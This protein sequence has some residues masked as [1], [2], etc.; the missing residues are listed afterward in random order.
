[1]GSIGGPETSS[2]KKLQIYAASHLR[3]AKVSHRNHLMAALFENG[4]LFLFGWRGS[5]RFHGGAGGT[6]DINLFW[7]AGQCRRH[8]MPAFFFFEE[9]RYKLIDII[10]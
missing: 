6:D 5:G 10:T 1:M 3:R 8:F 4:V 7:S 2:N 9:Q